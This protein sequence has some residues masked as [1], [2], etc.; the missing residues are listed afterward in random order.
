[1]GQPIKALIVDLDATQGR[2]SLSTKVLENFP[3]E[4]LE[5]LST[6]MAEADVRAEKALK[7]LDRGDA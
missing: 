4:I 2:I 1:V 5:N 7:K 6:V 3:G